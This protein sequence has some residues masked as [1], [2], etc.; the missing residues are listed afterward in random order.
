MDD[1]LKVCGLY[2][3]YGESFK[4]E[5]ITLERFEK[6]LLLNHSSVMTQILDKCQMTCGE[7][8]DLMAYWESLQ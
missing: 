4:Q 2:D 1:L 5:G 8:I 3:K 7:F 6:L